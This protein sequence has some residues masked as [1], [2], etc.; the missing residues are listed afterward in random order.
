M[1]G[2]EERE[3]GVVCDGGVRGVGALRERERDET[4]GRISRKERGDGTKERER[5]EDSVRSERERERALARIFRL[6]KKMQIFEN[7]FRIA[8]DC[9]GQPGSRVR[10][11]VGGQNAMT[12]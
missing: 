2:G 1:G 11:G 4:F 7:A 9:R 3:G 5:E 12:G 6:L 8:R 10:A